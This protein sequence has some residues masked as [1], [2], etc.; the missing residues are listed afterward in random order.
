MVITLEQGKILV[1]CTRV[2]AVEME[3]DSRDILI[4]SVG[5]GDRLDME[6][7]EGIKTS[8]WPASLDGE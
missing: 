7:K 5:L 4:K 8:S 2:V 3:T 6:G 1:A